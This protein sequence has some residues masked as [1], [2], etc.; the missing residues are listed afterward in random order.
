MTIYEQRQA[1]KARHERYKQCAIRR[2]ADIPGMTVSERA[3]VVQCERGA[4]VE[5]VIWIADEE[6]E[7]THA[8]QSD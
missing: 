7:E 4:F 1:T 5:A 3:G 6:L 8:V 2:V